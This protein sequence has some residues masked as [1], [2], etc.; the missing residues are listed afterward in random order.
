MPAHTIDLSPGVEKSLAELAALRNL[1][2]E[3]YMVQVL[4]GA[5]SMSAVTAADQPKTGR[6]LLEEWRRDGVMWRKDMTEDSVEYAY[7]LRE[8]SQRR[9]F[10]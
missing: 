3:E 4:E 7:R 2:L 8:R 6:E 10:D 1:S 5:V 9:S